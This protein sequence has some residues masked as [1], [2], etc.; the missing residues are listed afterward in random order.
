MVILR[1]FTSVHSI[2]QYSLIA[3]IPLSS[4]ARIRQDKDKRNLF[5]LDV[6][7]KL[8]CTEEKVSGDLIGELT[9]L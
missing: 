6:H 7:A 8:F 4:G 9:K 5:N 3:R 2:E 1:S